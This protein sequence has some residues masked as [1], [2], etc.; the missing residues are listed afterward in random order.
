MPQF[1]LFSSFCF[2]YSLPARHCVAFT[3]LPLILRDMF[4]CLMNCPRELI[5]R[6]LSARTYRIARGGSVHFESRCAHNSWTN[7]SPCTRIYR[8]IS[9]TRG[10]A[11]FPWRL[12]RSFEIPS[13]WKQRDAPRCAASSGDRRRANRITVT[14][15]VQRYNAPSRQGVKHRGGKFPRS[16]ESSLFIFTKCTCA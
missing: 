10:P 16:C 5:K 9:P 2:V 6:A 1:F 3:R 15:T 14:H 13:R 12:L 8:R 7:P 11:N 4:L